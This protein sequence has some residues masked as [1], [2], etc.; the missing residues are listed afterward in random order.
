[1]PIST[2]SIFGLS[3]SKWCSCSA[4]V[5]GCLW[6]IRT[7]WLHP[8]PF[9]TA[10]AENLLLLAPLVVVPLGLRVIGNSQGADTTLRAG[11]WRVTV[12]LQLPA[13]ILLLIAFALPVGM[14]AAG[15]ALP[16][17]AWTGLLA[18]CGLYRLKAGGFKQTG[19]LSIDAAMIYLV[20]GSGWLV[21]S[22]YGARPLEFEDVIVLLTAIH[23]HYAGFALPLLTGLVGRVLK[24]TTATSAAW[25]VIAGVPLVAAGITATQL[26]FSP[27]L[28][29][30]AA[31]VTAVAGL[32]TAWLHL[33]LSLFAQQPA[34]VR[35]LWLVSAGSLA[36][37]MVLAALY[38]CRHY[39]GV[40]GLD[41]PWMRAL[42]GSA[43]ALGFAL[44]GLLAWNWENGEWEGSSLV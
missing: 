5:G 21:L 1:M 28:E 38:G 10:W 40:P 37:G 18:L 22:R 32:L 12:L 7:A 15:C 29:V 43:D 13:A 34:F 31:W 3:F 8:T 42:H 30:L 4:I 41:I 23:F 2:S 19:E 20:V 6:L 36:A 16:W 27:F 9:E 35:T 14:G 44:V 33:R 11:L 26:K 25:G 39:G 24:G 17:L